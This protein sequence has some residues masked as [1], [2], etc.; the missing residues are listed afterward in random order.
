MKTIFTHSLK[1]LALGLILAA[2]VHSASA[3]ALAHTYVSGVG[4]DANVCS[5]TA[6]C[7][8]FQA[9][10]AN[11]ATG[12]VITALDAGDYGEVTITHAVTID[13]TG[14]QASIVTNSGS[15][16]ITISGGSSDTIILRHL[17]L[18]GLLNSDNGVVLNSGNLVMDDCKISGF[19]NDDGLYQDGTGT[20]LVE[21]TAITGCYEGIANYGSGLLSLRNVTLQGNQYGLDIEDG[22]T[23][24]SHS[25]VTQNSSMGLYA[26]GATV[27]VV[28][29][30]ISGDGVGVYADPGSIIRLTNND[31]LNNGTG[32]DTEN[33][34]VVASSGNNRKAGNA[35]SGSVTPGRVIAQQ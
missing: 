8:T 12:G 22:A 33:G 16:A 35:T 17:T 2:S 20:A 27:S 34:G 31:I 23:D 19:V 7:A 24:I 25:Q 21:N 3:T 26:Y 9:A 1:T 10:L 11:T 29:C 13:G 5:R 28:D 30:M 18:T 14:V 32:I 6:P 4:D 15:E